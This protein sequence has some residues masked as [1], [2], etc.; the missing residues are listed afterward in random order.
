MDYKSFTRILPDGI[1]NAGW[2]R[3]GVL[4]RMGWPSNYQALADLGI[5][6]RVNLRTMHS[7]ESE[8][9]AVGIKYVPFPINE[10]D[11]LIGN[12]KI[13]RAHV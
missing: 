1:P 2:V 7:D 9:L 8:C 11:P 3:D 5:K 10:A 4:L 6:T 12:G 13:G